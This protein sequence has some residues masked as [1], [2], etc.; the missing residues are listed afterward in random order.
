LY[1]SVP[2]VAAAARKMGMKQEAGAAAADLLM[3]IIFLLHPAK[4]LLLMLEP[5]VMVVAEGVTAQ[6]EPHLLY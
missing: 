1:V 6:Q 5:E 4:R 2:E 3:S